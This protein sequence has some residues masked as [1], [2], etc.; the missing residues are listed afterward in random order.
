MNTIK[1]KVESAWTPGP[2]KVGKD[3]RIEALGKCIIIDERVITAPC[4][5]GLHDAIRV[6][7]ANATL[8][9][10]APDL[11]EALKELTEDFEIWLLEHEVDPRT[12]SRL[13]LAHAAL[14]KAGAL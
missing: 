5:N 11:A 4:L 6:A 9:A 2:W 13:L 12:Q 3:R 10:A 8:I 14:K 1:D 7:E